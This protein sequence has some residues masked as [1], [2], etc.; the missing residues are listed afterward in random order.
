[1]IANSKESK[2]K[3]SN[4]ADHSSV[5]LAEGDWSMEFSATPRTSR[6]PKMDV[7]QIVEVLKTSTPNKSNANEENVN[8]END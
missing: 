2:I 6:F 1:M 4:P 5:S 7:D 8:E 3:S